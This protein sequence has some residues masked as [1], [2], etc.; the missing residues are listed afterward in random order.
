MTTAAQPN[1]TDIAEPATA[2][3]V[4]LERIGLLLLAAVPVTSLAGVV[5]LLLGIFNAPLAIALG[6]AAGLWLARRPLRAP[7]S[8][9]HWPGRSGGYVLLLLMF[10]ALLRWPPGLHVQGGRDHGVYMAMAAHFVE[11]GKLEVVDDLAERLASPD[12]VYRFYQNNGMQPGAY[13]DPARRGHYDFQFYHVHPIWLAIFGGLFGMQLAG[14]SQIFFA[15]LSIL[16]AALVAERLTGSW[17]AGLAY[18]AVLAILPLHVFFSKFAIS[19]LPTLAFALMAAYAM[20]RY[21]HDDRPKADA[22]W[23]QLATLAFATLFLTRISG[24]VYLPFAY[25]GAVACQVFV[26]DAGRRSAWARFWLALFACYFASV[27]Y[28]LVWSKP[29]SISIYEMHF[30]AGLLPWVP[31]L[32]AAAVVAGA[33]PFLFLRGSFRDRMRAKLQRAWNVAQRWN[34][35]LLLAIV[36]LGAIRVGL[37][38]FTDHY[39]GN[40]WYDTTWRMSHGGLAAIESSALVVSGEYLGPAVVVL[41]FFALWKTGNSIPRALLTV[42]VLVMFAYAALLQWFLPLQ[43]YYGRYLL[44]EIVPFALLLVVVRCADWW[45]SAALRPWISATGALAIAYFLWFTLPLIGTTE[46]SD[47]ETSLARI[48][49]QMDG[50][51]VLLVDETNIVNPHRFETPLRFWFGKQVYPIRRWD[52]IYDIVRDLRRAGMNDLL[53]LSGDDDVPAPF[54]FDRHLRFEQHA[55]ESKLTIPRHQTL[56]TLDLSLSRL[57]RGIL[58]PNALAKGVA[59]ADLP[60]GCCSGFFPRREWTRESASI[61]VPMPQGT[62]HRLIMTMWGFRHSYDGIGLRVSANGVELPLIEAS[63]WRFVYSLDSVDPATSLKLQIQSTMFV[64]AEAGISID[65]RR[66]GVDIARLQVE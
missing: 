66:L 4:P 63:G 60:P 14:L 23:L 19:E 3:G 5:L 34:P 37:L 55:M 25:A 16:F 33:V 45:P 50:S 22:R 41:L 39:R 20:L 17:R 29:Y 13:P 40:A 44:S 15:L 62:W 57:G 9:A 52:Q 54:E 48:A 35:A 18:A 47:G 7:G 1:S 43:Y 59:L 31:W 24:F 46:G 58:S 10:A 2:S 26:D 27:V 8:R 12:A 28:G 6:V 38:A 36:I 11:K 49:D 65:E 51:S 42:M 64:P 32:V 30:G 53:L 21:A 61:E 56:D